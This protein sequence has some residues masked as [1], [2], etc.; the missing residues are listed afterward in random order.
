MAQEYVCTS[1]GQVSGGK[2]ITKGSLS[3][4]FFLW[5]CFLIPGLIYSI[6]RLTTRYEACPKCKSA[7]II[8]VDS[9]KGR[10]LVE[11]NKA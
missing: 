5:I 10:K 2:T 3:M 4:E 9:P 8:P 6:W 11:E 7:S 1:C